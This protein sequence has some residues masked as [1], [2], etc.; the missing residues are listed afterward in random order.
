[1]VDERSRRRGRKLFA[2]HRPAPSCV[3]LPAGIPQ[4]SIVVVDPLAER[5]VGFLEDRAE[6]SDVP[7]FPGTTC[8][9]RLELPAQLAHRA[10]D[11]DPEKSP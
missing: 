11:S 6:L 8:S 4:Q 7:L 9:L 10:E 3:L 2:P 1:M 5:A